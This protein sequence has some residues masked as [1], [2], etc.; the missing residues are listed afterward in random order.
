MV[1]TPRCGVH[2]ARWTPPGIPLYHPTVSLVPRKKLPH[3][4]LL[5]ID[6]TTETYFITVGCLPRGQNHLAIP[7]VAEPLI[8]TAVY[9][10]EQSIWSVRLLLLM[11]DHVH[12]LVSFPDN[13]KR[14]STIMSKWKEW[15]A[16]HLAIRWQ[17][18]FF[19]HR[20]RR[21]ESIREKADYI[22]AN[23]VRAGLVTRAEDWAFVFIP[24]P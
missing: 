1:G 7:E 6:P 20:L 16:K 19:E 15:T 11:P 18:D 4:V 8:E 17:R 14:I 13:G 23:P 12:F 22:L 2:S 24:E 21:D 5:W 10:N 3:N 9:R